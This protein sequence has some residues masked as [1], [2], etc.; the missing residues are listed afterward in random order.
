M[1]Y[2]SGAT[3]YRSYGPMA[4]SDLAGTES[5]TAIQEIVRYRNYLIAYKAALSAA[6]TQAQTDYANSLLAQANQYKAMYLSRG[7]DDLTSMD[8]AILAV[9]DTISGTGKVLN[10]VIDWATTKTANVLTKAAGPLI[11]ILLAGGA[12]FYFFSKRGK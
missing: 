9:A 8:R 11:P 12:M 5:L 7:D 3:M 2:L 6:Q 4:P 10:D 1:S